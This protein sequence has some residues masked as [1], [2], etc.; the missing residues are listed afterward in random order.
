MFV[1]EGAIRVALGAS[2]VGVRQA[3]LGDGLKL[4]VAGLAFGLVMARA[5]GR[6]VES[7]LFEVGAG[8]VS[9]FASVAALLTVVAVAA[10]YVP[11][12]RASRADPMSVLREE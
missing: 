8:D 9:V 2:S 7:M 4:V 1:D 6:F 10:T 12:F 5:L 3:V 11:A